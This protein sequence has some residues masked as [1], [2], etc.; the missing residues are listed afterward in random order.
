MFIV[1]EY[2]PIKLFQF[3][4]FVVDKTF[5]AIKIIFRD[6]Q[7]VNIIKTT[8]FKMGIPFQSSTR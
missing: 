7:M 2:S 8:C 5:N 3:M 4:L 6:I 1:D